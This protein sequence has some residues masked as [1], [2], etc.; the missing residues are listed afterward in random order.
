MYDSTSEDEYLA[1]EQLAQRAVENVD[2]MDE[3]TSSD[4]ESQSVARVDP[5]FIE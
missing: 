5:Y 4:D 2:F 1:Q 3:L